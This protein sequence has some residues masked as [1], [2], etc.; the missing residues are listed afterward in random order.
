MIITLKAILLTLFMSLVASAEDE[1]IL[2]YTQPA[3]RWEEALP[4]GNGR[5]GAMVFGSVPCERLQ[6]NEESLWAGA[7]CDAYPDDFAAHLGKVQ[8]L[9]LDGKIVEARDYGLQN[10]TKKPTSFRSYEPLCDLLI[11]M[12]HAPEVDGY[13]REL[14]LRTGIARVQYSAAG[15]RITREI[16]ISAVDDVVAVRLTAGKP[17]TLSAR[18]RLTRQKDMEVIARGHDEAILEFHTEAGISYDLRVK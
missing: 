6:L 1:S 10:L 14:D 2:W 18:I 11:E 9:V 3:K 15:V 17:G 16:L 12:D 8:Q 13:K 7:P 4:L 5:M